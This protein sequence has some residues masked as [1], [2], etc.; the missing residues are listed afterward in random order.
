MISLKKILTELGV[1]TEFTGIESQSDGRNYEGEK[2]KNKQSQIG[3]YSGES[4]LDPEI[5]DI[6]DDDSP[7]DPIKAGDYDELNYENPVYW[8]PNV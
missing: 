8:N 5:L 2:V 1:L 6:S 3:K 7:Y 4:M